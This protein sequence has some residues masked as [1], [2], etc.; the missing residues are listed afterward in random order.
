VYEAITGERANYGLIA[1]QSFGT[2]LGNSMVAEVVRREA[3]AAN[4]GLVVSARGQSEM[5]AASGRTLDAA[6]AQANGAGGSPIDPW[7]LLRKSPAFQSALDKL[8]GDVSVLYD[9]SLW[10]V[11]SKA[12]SGQGLD[13]RFDDDSGRIALL[14][15]EVSALAS[16]VRLA[17][18]DLTG[19]SDGNPIVLAVRSGASVDEL[20]AKV[21]Q[22]LGRF[23][24]HDDLVG[25]TSQL[26]VADGRVSGSQFL[27]LRPL[28]TQVTWR[29][30]QYIYSNPEY[31]QKLT[32]LQD[33]ESRFA[34]FAG[35][36]RTQDALYSEVRLRQAAVDGKL[37]QL[38]GELK[39]GGLIPARILKSQE[40]G[41]YME[42]IGTAMTMAVP[43][44][45]AVRGAM[46]IAARVNLAEKL[47]SLGQRGF[48]W[49]VER[50]ANVSGREL[51]GLARTE[52]ALKTQLKQ[53]MELGVDAVI[54][55]GPKIQLKGPFLKED[56]SG[57]LSHEEQV[58]GID[59]SIKRAARNT[60]YDKLVIDTL[61][62]SPKNYEYLMQELVKVQ[63][64]VQVIR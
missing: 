44:G 38:T 27:D 49:S 56:L 32:T 39:D 24:S 43:V 5:Q 37:E 61:G 50:G 14:P 26:N 36:Y 23:V 20:G 46:N 1:A 58:A 29:G 31:I 18:P 40:L 2:A 33:A 41:R 42:W 59:S 34:S 4:G 51:L 57:L 47:I 13:F 8:G 6:S 62:L 48:L 11:L 12:D 19:T 9:T 7:D 63:K 17:A 16:G 15:N 55:R 25:L 64:P 10:S 3:N 21:T 54:P 22:H 30:L 35:N 60:A 45:P 28:Q 53:S 52:I